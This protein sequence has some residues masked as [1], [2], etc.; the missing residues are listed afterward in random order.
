MLA[1]PRVSVETAVIP[2]GYISKLRL[3][4]RSIREATLDASLLRFGP[5]MKTALVACLGLLPAALS[6]G[7]G[8]DAQKLFAVVVVAR[9]I[10][11]LILGFVNPVRYEVV[12]G[13]GNVLQ[14]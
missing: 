11:R 12:A 3:E 9:L 10:S 13:E 6:T 2:V 7:L 8:G 14:V 4:G 5:I 1:L